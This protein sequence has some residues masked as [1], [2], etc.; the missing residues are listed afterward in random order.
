LVVA[1]GEHLSLSP[2]GPCPERFVQGFERIRCRRRTS[3]RGECR[4]DAFGTFGSPESFAYCLAE[5]VRSKTARGKPGPG[6]GNL[7]SASYF[8]L[9]ATERNSTNGYTMRQRLLCGAHAGVRNSARGTLQDR[10]MGQEGEDARICRCGDVISVF[11]RQGC[12]HVHVLIRECLER[13]ANQSPVI[14]ELR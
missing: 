2:G 4:S 6:V 12:H 1:A 9:I 11:G 8:Q 5:T 14:L 7:H 3:C 13:A 10:R